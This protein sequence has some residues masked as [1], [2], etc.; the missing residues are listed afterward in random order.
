MTGTRGGDPPQVCVVGAGLRMV[1]VAQP[2]VPR[3]G[4]VCCVD[5][6]GI[7]VLLWAGAVGVQGWGS[8]AG[9]MEIPSRG[10]MSEMMLPRGGCGQIGGFPAGDGGKQPTCQCRRCA[11]DP[12]VGRT[13]WRRQWQ[14]TPMLL[15]GA[16][17]GQRSLVG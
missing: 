13:P 11:F 2:A 1:R 15:P 5:T 3:A 17:G 4:R 10:G 9:L 6:R 7:C 16:S 14:P 8:K 12:R